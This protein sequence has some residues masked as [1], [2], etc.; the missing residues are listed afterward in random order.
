MKETDAKEDWPSIAEYNTHRQSAAHTDHHFYQPD[1]T[2]KEPG[3]KTQ[4]SSVLFQW[5]KDA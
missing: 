1:P 3:W 5:H 2:Q 4:P